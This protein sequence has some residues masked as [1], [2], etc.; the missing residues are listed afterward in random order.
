[1]RTGEYIFRVIQ[2]GIE[3]FLGHFILWKLEISAS[4]M[5]H[6]ASSFWD[7]LLH[8]LL[9]PFEC[10]ASSGRALLGVKGKRSARELSKLFLHVFH[11][12]GISTHPY[13]FGC[14]RTVRTQSGHLGWDATLKCRNLLICVQYQVSFRA[15]T[16]LHTWINMLF[17]TWK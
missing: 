15:K 7:T 3:R 17:H 5:I 16:Y 14:C 11:R 8:F 2:F 6:L 4:L 1:M 13:V 9:S 12:G 10:S